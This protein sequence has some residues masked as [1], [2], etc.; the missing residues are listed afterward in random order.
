MSRI[1]TAEAVQT[2]GSGSALWCSRYCWI[3]GDQVGHA[4][5]YSAADAVVGDQAKELLGLVEPAGRRRGD[6]H[7]EPLVPRQPRPRLGMYARG[8]VVA[9][10]VHIEMLRRLTSIRRRN[11]TC[12]TPATNTSSSLQ[13][14]GS[15]WMRTIWA[16]AAS[17]PCRSPRPAPARR[18]SSRWARTAILTCSIEPTWAAWAAQWPC[19][20]RRGPGR[21][22]VRC[23][24]QGTPPG[25]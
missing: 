2:Q 11:P 21:R 25:Q 22:P 10:C 13:Q 23:F 1:A 12:A 20:R 3:A 15:N 17:R 4:R 18:Y 5:K 6:M 14:T 24:Q 8:I 7:V 19:A 16:S 9:D